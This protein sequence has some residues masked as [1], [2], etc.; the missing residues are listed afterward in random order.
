MPGNRFSLS[1]VCVR[2]KY[3]EFVTAVSCYPVSTSGVSG[4]D[5]SYV[6]KQTVTYVVAV[7]KMC[8]RDRPLFWAKPT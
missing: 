7:G 5:F 4:D 3:D 1:Q 2:T 6:D 8:I